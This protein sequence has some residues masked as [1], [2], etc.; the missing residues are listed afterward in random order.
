MPLSRY[1][2]IFVIGACLTGAVLLA[3]QPVRPLDD[4]D[5][6]DGTRSGMRPLTDHLTGCQYLAS[7]FGG[8]TPRIDGQSHHVGCRP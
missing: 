2:A 7:G 8:I 1:V 3:S 5:A 6:P 4:S